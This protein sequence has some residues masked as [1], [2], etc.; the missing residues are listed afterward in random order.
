MVTVQVVPELESQS[1]HP[2][3][4]ES[5]CGVAVSVTTVP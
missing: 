4:T 1:A 5:S 3:K 2:S